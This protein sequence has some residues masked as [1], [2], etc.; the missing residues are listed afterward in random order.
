MKISKNLSKSDKTDPS[1]KIRM[2]FFD[3]EGTSVT[4]FP[5]RKFACLYSWDMLLLECKPEE[6]TKD[7]MQECTRHVEG[8]DVSS[9][10]G[11]LTR[12]MEDASEEGYYWSV[13]VHN[14][15]YDFGYLRHLFVNLDN[16]GYTVSVVAKSSTYLLTVKV[17]KGKREVLVLYDTLA[18]FGV[19]LR[20][21]GANLGY[22]K[23]SIDYLERLAPDSA[24]SEDNIAYNRRDT[25]VLALAVCKSLLTRECV[26]AEDLGHTIL[27]RTS[28]VRVGDRTARRIGRLPLSARK[29]RS[30]G[31]RN[32]VAKKPRMN[33]VYDADRSTVAMHQYKSLSDY[34]R[35]SSYG[36]SVT[37]DVKGFFAGGVNVSN[38]NVIGKV[39]RNVISYDLK[40]AY[41]AIMLSYRVPCNPVEIPC[42]RLS[43]Y[44]PLLVDEAPSPIDVLQCK[45]YFW[46]GTVRFEGIEMDDEW[47]DS[48]GD[49]SV[50]QT[51]V[52]QNFKRSEGVRFKD[53]YMTGAK[54][55][56][57]TMCSSEYYEVLLQYHWDSASFDSLTVYTQSAMPTYYTVIRTLNHFAEKSIAKKV[58]KAFAK[59][60]GIS[61]T[62]LDEWLRE[63]YVTYDEREA[64]A[65][66]NVD[67]YWIENFVLS[68]K[69]NLN[70]LYGI[71]VTNPLKDE[72]ELNAEGYLMTTE[73]DVFE[74]YLESSR[75][76]KMWRESGV[77]IAVYNRY[78][79]TYM[80]RMQVDA[81]GTVVY[82]DTDSIK[83]VG[84]SKDELDELYKPLHDEI[85][86]VTGEL[87]SHVV[88]T[89]N[90]KM[91]ACSEEP[92]LQVPDDSEFRALGKLD[93]EG[94]Y[95]KFL[96][97]GHKKYAYFDKGR[98]HVKCSGY[99]LRMLESL[100]AQLVECGC[101]D[102][103]PV[104]ALGFDNR[105]DSTTKV[106]SVSLCVPETWVDVEFEA[107]DVSGD[108]KST[109]VYKGSTCPGYAIEDAGKIMN[110][111]DNSTMNKMRYRAA[112]RNNEAVAECSRIDIAYID[113]E[114][115]LGKRGRVPMQ[116]SDWG[117]DWTNAERVSLL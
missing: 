26:N 102:L 2:A 27:T 88:S 91:A 22:N 31:K 73:S 64:I 41:P 65:S 49:S 16:L 30:T 94:V 12:M 84:L 45:G 80:A 70:S 46:V 58:Q 63:G 59:G 57:L 5:N 105:Y 115:R 117:T 48:V 14:L 56:Y 68:H 29:S 96:T 25:E 69:G 28:I 89:V 110:N 86:R 55:L 20:T 50:T 93:Y 53:G 76:S 90:G 75:D 17:K 101:G 54:V 98:W 66:G 4:Y 52:L 100:T 37:K 83:S 34:Y 61:E 18:L 109:H 43:D 79:I 9:L 13:A 10:Y 71:A 33:T 104:I 35:W 21:L 62:E 39:L 32:R 116:W 74:R 106:A 78:K 82:V 47:R 107:Q 108:C 114:Y 42:K 40:S 95:Q 81:G 92:P 51:M 24:L 38:A 8:R 87:V 67:E 60:I 44:A 72:Y 113:G 103:S 99:N 15:S 36:D 11:E 1:E 111:T 23:L 6:L 97:M 7:N 112:C 85:E 3:T 19:S 77:C